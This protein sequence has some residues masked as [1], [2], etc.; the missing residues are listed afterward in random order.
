MTMHLRLAP[1]IAAVVAALLTSIAS[2]NGAWALEGPEDS[3]GGSLQETDPATSDGGGVA[4]SDGVEGGGSSLSFAEPS[5]LLSL[6]AETPGQRD[7]IILD[8]GRLLL[9]F[10]LLGL[11]S[12]FSMTVPTSDRSFRVELPR[13][14][15]AEEFL[16][17]AQI[18]IG[19]GSGL[20][21]LLVDGRRMAVSPLR[22][23]SEALLATP[24]RFPLASDGMTG[25]TGFTLRARL[26]DVSDV[27]DERIAVAPLLIQDAGIVV[28]G[29][30]E[31]PMTIAD[32]LPA[33]LR[34]VYIHVDSIPTPAEATAV[35]RL[36][37]DLVARYGALPLDVR[38]VASPRTAAVPAAVDE[39]MTRTFVVRESATHDA[40][41][42]LRSP[43][44]PVIALRAPAEQLVSQPLV[45]DAL[46]VRLAQAERVRVDRGQVR[47]QLQPVSRTFDELGIGSPRVSAIGRTEL[48]VVVDLTRLRGPIA[49][50]DVRLE[51]ASTPLAQGEAGSVTLAARGEVIL[52]Q[53]LDGSGTDVIDVRIPGRL[54]DRAT[55]LEVTIDH[56]PQG[57]ACAPGARPLQLQF[58]S[59]SEITAQ[60]V[61]PNQPGFEGFRALPHR[62][63]PGFDVE[64]FPLD[65]ARLQSATAIM[66]GVQSLTG[67]PLLPTA[68]DGARPAAGSEPTRPRLI[69][70]SSRD[71]HPFIGEQVHIVGPGVYEVRGNLDI[72]LELTGS[73]AILQS[74]TDLS[75]A[76]VL[77]A[78]GEDDRVLSVLLTWLNE[79]T[80]RWYGLDGDTVVYGGSADP[81]R[82]LTLRPQPDR[83][84]SLT[85]I[86]EFFRRVVAQ[87][88]AWLG[89][90][91]SAWLIVA[92]VV[93]ILSTL[94]VRLIRRRR[95]SRR[96]TQAAGS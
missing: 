95:A 29:A 79:E 46:V 36:T 3:V 27:C 88:A 55:T 5:P 85:G 33:L 64:L 54:L 19:L 23:P 60:V 20:L 57:G 93:G 26:G 22:E 40:I 41:E 39:P 74:F 37:A 8:D 43:T 17:N 67:T 47:R 76:P 75:G 9:P 50:V 83:A 11:P 6:L 18:P 21:E 53:T 82:V 38:V 1:A 59:S 63:Q 89:A 72:D 4:V 31:Q 10:G 70:R 61:E 25:V 81:P 90:I 86:L 52:S 49:S 12:S 34:R 32:A 78:H 48:P 7:P 80:G 66:R 68:H 14:L 15:A 13:G 58:L 45:F 92:T 96:V 51:I 69:V 35:L 71:L 73:L 65:L 24:L 62:F 84:D 91:N 30:V 56:S 16:A 42:L 87:I 44:G 28:S 2:T 77:L 94:G